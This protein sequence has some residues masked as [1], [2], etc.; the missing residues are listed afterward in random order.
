MKLLRTLTKTALA[1]LIVAVV[2]GCGTARRGEP[3][4]G[5]F[6]PAA[7]SVSAGKKVYQERCDACHPGGEAGVGPGLND[8]PLPRFLMKFQV[9]HGLGAMPSFP[10]ETLSDEDVERLLDYIQAIRKHGASAPE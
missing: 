1:I 5:T 2:A 7:D 8:K 3:I 9:R 6:A 10:E 4:A